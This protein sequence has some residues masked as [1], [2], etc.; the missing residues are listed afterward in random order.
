[1]IFFT[2]LNTRHNTKNLEHKTQNSQKL[3]TW[4]PADINTKC[5][6]GFSVSK[7]IMKWPAALCLCLW[8]AGVW[9][10]PTFASVIPR[11][12]RLGCPDFRP[13]IF[14][15]WSTVKGVRVSLPMIDRRLWFPDF[16]LIFLLLAGGC[17]SPIEWVELF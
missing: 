9:D 13:D 17:Y 14:C 1:M 11:L 16:F 5:K 6:E 4:T 3:K 7:W 8:L 10:F 15:N 2:Y 12:S